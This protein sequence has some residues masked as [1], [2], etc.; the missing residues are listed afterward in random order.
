MLAR[1]LLWP[2][3]LVHGLAPPPVPRPAPAMPAPQYGRALG[4]AQGQTTSGGT[5]LSITTTAD[6]NLGEEIVVYVGAAGCRTITSV[7]DSAGNTYAAMTVQTSTGS[8]STDAAGRMFRAK[9]TTALATGGT[10][11]ATCTGLTTGSTSLVAATALNVS[12]AT[13][14]MAVANGGSGE[15]TVNITTVAPNAIIFVGTC[16]KDGTAG[17]GYTEDNT[18]GAAYTN[19]Y[20]EYIQLSPSITMHFAYRI[21]SSVQSPDTYNPT[22]GHN[23]KWAQNIGALA[24]ATTAPAQAHLVPMTGGG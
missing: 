20:N 18:G 23:V 15:P 24:Q 7:A 6:A 11:T 8:A 9:V 5:T 17:T 16:Q 21:V 10:I 3:L 19:I 1:L 12:N 4:R 13:D 14:S 22:T 2:V